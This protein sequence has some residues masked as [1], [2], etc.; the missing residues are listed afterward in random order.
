MITAT[1]LMCDFALRGSFATPDVFGAGRRV[2]AVVLLCATLLP[3][4][5]LFCGFV[6]FLF[7]ELTNLTVD[8]P[9]C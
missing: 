3:D 9:D 4:T 8:T 1:V 6:P 5:A 7:A 2:L